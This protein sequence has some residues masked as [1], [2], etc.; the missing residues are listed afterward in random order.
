MKKKSGKKI[1][2]K[3]DQVESSRW[4]FEVRMIVAPLR[5]IDGEE[6]DAAASDLWQAIYEALE[7]ECVSVLDID[8]DQLIITRKAEEK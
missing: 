4:L 5:M 3:V 2:K 7:G 6:P 8:L 1:Q